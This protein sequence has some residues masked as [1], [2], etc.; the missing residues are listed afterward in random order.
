MSEFVS[1]AGQKL[2][3]ALGTFGIDV[4][5]K[6]CADLGSNTGGFV[7]CLLGRG[8]GKVYAIDTG[9]G[10]L[11]WKL[12]KDARVVVMERTNAM[13]AILP[14][15]AEIVTIDVAW[16]KQK[17]ILP[18]ARRMLAEGGTVVTLVKPHYEA[19]AG[20]LRKGILMPEALEGVLAG[21][22]RDIEMAG[23]R[24]EALIPSP[25]QGGKG[26]FEFLGHLRVAGT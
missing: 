2:E 22:R 23:F 19:E 9:Y 11:A 3:H 8:A 20:Q 17:H 4:A 24:L 18:A 5:G 7:D 10:A 26:N 21:V 14:E 16:T 13:H 12:R 6:V 15:P 25:I 1:R